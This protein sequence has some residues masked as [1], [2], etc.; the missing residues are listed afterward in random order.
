MKI[1]IVSDAGAPQVNGVVRT[2]EHTIEELE[3]LG[4]TVMLVVPS[5][6]KTIPLLGYPEIRIP[7][8]TRGLARRIYDYDPDYIHISTEGKLGWA[9]R[10]LCIRW[11]WK[12]TTAYHT[13]FPSY[14]AEHYSIPRSMT[15]AGLRKFHDASSAIMVSTQ[16]VEDELLERGFR[17]IVRWGR[18]VDTELFHS[19]DREP[20]PNP[21][22]LNVGRVSVEKNLDD[23]CKLSIDNARKIVVGDGPAMATYQDRYPDVEFMGK[24]TGHELADIYAQAD[25]FVFPSRSDTFG[26]VIIEALACGTPVAAYP[27][28]GP[29]DILTDESGAMS[30]NLGEAVVEA[31]TRD[32]KVVAEFGKKFTWGYATK[33]FISALVPK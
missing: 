26:L 12:F 27:V 10:R 33:Q 2:L 4:H 1:L 21:I 30:E 15:Y 6:F 8:S 11:G 17:N 13:D 19:I 32:R 3:K 22:L 31:L 20:N 9:A 16:S 5:D 29:R 23:F 24:K 18:G 25:C 7:I 14:L 28:R